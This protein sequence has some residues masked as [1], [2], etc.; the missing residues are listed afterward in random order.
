MLV[1][2]R[3]WMTAEAFNDAYALCQFLPG[4]NVFNLSAAVSAAGS[5][6][7]SRWWD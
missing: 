4:P 5:A 7:R 2:E 3:G 1:E 6:L